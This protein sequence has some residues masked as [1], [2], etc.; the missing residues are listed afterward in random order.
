MIDQPPIVFMTSEKNVCHGQAIG[1]SLGILQHY[2]VAPLWE[3]SQGDF[4]ARQFANRELA[5]HQERVA[6]LNFEDIAVPVPRFATAKY[7]IVY[8]RLAVSELFNSLWLP[9][10]RGYYDETWISICHPSAPGVIRPR[11]AR[12]ISHASSPGKQ[13]LQTSGRSS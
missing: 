13:S 3:G 7:Q 10:L 5:G 9:L 8:R 1:I 6:E 4:R 11:A 2:F 12:A